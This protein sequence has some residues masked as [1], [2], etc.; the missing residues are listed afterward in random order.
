MGRRA[1]ESSRQATVLTIQAID[2][3]H[4]RPRRAVRL[5]VRAVKRMAVASSCSRGGAWRRPRQRPTHNSLRGGSQCSRE[6][7]RPSTRTSHPLERSS[8]A[9]SRTASRACATADGQRGHA[10]PH[11][12][13]LPRIRSATTTCFDHTIQSGVIKNSGSVHPH[14]HKPKF[15]TWFSKVL[16]AIW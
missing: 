9:G 14:A 8:V 6:G 4:Q 5:P 11:A 10:R 12:S 13:R 2:G 1:A 16:F 7:G 3:E 15:L